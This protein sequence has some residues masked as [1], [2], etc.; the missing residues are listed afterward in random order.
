MPNLILMM[1]SSLLAG[2][3]T[4]AGLQAE[5]LA[6]RHQLIVLQRTQ[7]KKRLILRPTDRWLWVWLSR[8]WLDWRSAL[9]IVKPATVIAWHRQGFRWYWTWKIRH[10]RTGRP[11][12]PKET[13][14][15]IRTISQD[16]P[17]WGSPRI[18]G[19]LLK[20]GINVSQA[21]VAK[22]MVRPRKPPSQTWRTFLT[23]HVSQLV[24]TD[25]CETAT[26]STDT[27]SASNSKSWTSKKS[28]APRGR[29]GNELTSSA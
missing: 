11:S 25:F 4:Q 7:K 24:S 15:L 19:E 27:S 8:V 12:I 14:D 5:I 21:S 6:L 3:R 23:N 2:L 16:N 29:R 28:S 26:G 9:V 10:G 22:Y 13:R 17:L 18:H 20:L 1:F